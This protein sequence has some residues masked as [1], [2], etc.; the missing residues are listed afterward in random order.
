MILVIIIIGIFVFLFFKQNANLPPGEGIN[1]GS[2][3]NPFGPS[4]VTPP[5]TT[6]PAD[7]SGYVP[8]E[9]KPEEKNRLRKVSS[10]PIAGY[11]I[12]SKERLIDVL[13]T[14]PAPETVAITAPSTDTGTSSSTTSKTPI[15]K[16]TTTTKPTPPLTEFMPSL[17]YVAREN[18]NIYQTFADKIE[19][20]RFSTTIIPKVYEAYF[21][22][23]AESVV[24]R[25]L[26]GD[27]V[28]IDTFIGVLPKEYLGADTTGNNEIKGTF[29]PENIKDVSLSP[30]AGSLFY[31]FN[32]GDSMVGTTINLLN[33]KKEQVFE[34]SFTDWLSLWPA[35]KIINLTTK[36]SFGVPGYTYA[37]DL[38]TKNFNKVFGGI[39]G[40]TTLTSPDGKSILYGNNTLSLNIY[41]TD[42]KTTEVLGVR[43]LPEKCVWGKVGD[44]VYCSVPRTIV[45]SEFPDVWYQGEISFSDQ[46]WKIDTATG[47]ATIVVD[48]TTEKGGEDIDG[49][50]LML[51]AGENY[52]LFVNK[53]DSFLWELDL[54]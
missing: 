30:D 36:P 11:T 12:F 27:G 19:E 24:M 39:N 35:N 32:V 6:P 21:G 31:L 23:K 37:I 3:F 45:S 44:F 16:K 53:K 38:I 33:N 50:K 47:N 52:L 42:T 17:R 10:M 54:K 2:I 48:P 46:I 28:T 49:T 22:N 43:T 29:L 26:K 15:V 40:L 7:V 14:T 8:P 51:D 9:T 4:K 34:S 41:H 1:F 18:G 25:Y 5:T 20:R 13:A